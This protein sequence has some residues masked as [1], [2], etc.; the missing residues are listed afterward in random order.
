MSIPEL[1]KEF[2]ASRTP[3]RQAIALLVQN[4]IITTARRRGTFVS[5]QLASSTDD[6]SL[7]ISI[8]DP[9]VLGQGQTF[10]VLTRTAV[11]RLPDEFP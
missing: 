10:K 3:V 1:Y 7:R 2:G 5:D 11:D 4:G 8:S 9:L 6:D